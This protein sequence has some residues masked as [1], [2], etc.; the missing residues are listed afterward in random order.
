M[1]LVHIDLKRLLKPSDRPL[2]LEIEVVVFNYLHSTAFL[3][4]QQIVQDFFEVSL[5]IG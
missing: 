3:F 4:H 2:D 5:P 1:N